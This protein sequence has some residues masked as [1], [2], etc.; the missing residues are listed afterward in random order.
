MAD[1]DEKTHCSICRSDLDSALRLSPQDHEREH[2]E[3]DRACGQC[4]EAWLSLQVEEKKPSEIEC[5]FC[6]SHI[7]E[8][9]L[10]SLAR[11]TT[12]TRYVGFECQMV[13]LLLIYLD[14]S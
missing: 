1:S 12:V 2:G 8:D 10:L 13:T 5:M 6:T 4:W 9:D 14:T 7:S 3:L 11:V